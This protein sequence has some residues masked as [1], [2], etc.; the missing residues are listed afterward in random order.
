MIMRALTS[1]ELFLH[2]DFYCKNPS[3]VTT[4]NAYSKL[5][6]SVESILKVSV[7][8]DSFSTGLNS[9]DL[10]KSEALRNCTNA[11]WSSY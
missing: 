6:C 2:S 11:T 3:F 1:L 10:I 7:S 4:L 9:A 5:F 8:E